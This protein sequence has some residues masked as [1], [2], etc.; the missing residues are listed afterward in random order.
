MDQMIHP[1]ASSVKSTATVV[2]RN[3]LKTIGW[4]PMGPSLQ[5]VHVVSRQSRLSVYRVPFLVKLLI[6]APV[7]CEFGVGMIIISQ[8]CNSGVNSPVIHVILGSSALAGPSYH[9]AMDAIPGEA[10][11]L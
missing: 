1:I 3:N 4:A 6:R 8:L 2:S 9:Q 10:K 11:L 5:S 7:M